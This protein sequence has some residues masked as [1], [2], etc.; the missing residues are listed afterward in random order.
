MTGV[1]T[2]ALPIYIDQRKLKT[3][4]GNVFQVPNEALALAVAAE[5]NGQKE[6]IKRQFMHIV[7]CSSFSFAQGLFY[8]VI[9]F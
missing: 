7:S 4:M 3:P 1:Q 8:S 5:W 2:C 6:K 9:E